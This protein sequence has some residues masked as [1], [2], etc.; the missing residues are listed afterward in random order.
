MA[1][2]F[3]LVLLEAQG[4]AI[5]DLQLHGD[6]V[7]TGDGLGNRMLD[8]YAAVDLE[9][10]E[11]ARRVEHELDGAEVAVADRAR[12][13]H[14]GVV[15]RGSC[16]R[17]QRRRR[18]LL[19]DLL[20]AALDRAVALSEMARGTVLVGRDLDLNVARGDDKALDV[21]AAVSERRVGLTAR[22]SEERASSCSSPASLIPRPPPPA[23]AFSS[24]G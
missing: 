20:I 21:D 16:L 8:L 18:R 5:G 7:A 19:D 17:R 14:R 24:T 11:L 6:E 23:A 13:L 10:I 3:H 1:F 9:E 12:E 2:E 4:P 22:Q 15:E